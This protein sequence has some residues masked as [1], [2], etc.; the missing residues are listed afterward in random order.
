MPEDNPKTKKQTN[1]ALEVARGSDKD[2]VLNTLN[3]V[4]STFRAQLQAETPNPFN[5][6]GKIAVAT[7]NDIVAR[8][9]FDTR[10]RAIQELE[11]KPLSSTQIQLTWTDAVGNA[12]GYRVERCQGDRCKDL[13]EVGRAASTERSFTDSTLSPST[14]YGYRVVA[15]NF[16][17]ETPS[18]CV[19]YV[20]TLSTYEAE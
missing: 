19:F 11:G 18:E 2:R 16:R 13:A 9:R 3:Q 15:F 5:D 4:F 14:T 12:D 7:F 6:N 10:P 8:L 1:E 20:K 17:G